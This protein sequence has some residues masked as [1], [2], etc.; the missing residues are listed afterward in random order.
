MKIIAV[1]TCVLILALASCATTQ[2]GGAPGEAGGAAAGSPAAGQAPRQR[3][4]F[5]ARELVYFTAGSP[6]GYAAGALNEYTV[7]EWNSGFTNIVQETRYSASDAALE[8]TEYTYQ[9]NSPAAKIIKVFVPDEK[10]KAQEQVRTQVEYQYDQGRL[11]TETLKNKDGNVVTLYEYVYDGQGNLT[12]RIMKN[13]KGAVMAETVYTWTGGRRVSA[14][15]KNAGGTIISSTQ[16]QYDRQGSLVKEE[17]RNAGGKVTSV[18]TITWQNGLEVKSELTGA[19]NTPQ[20]RETN[21]Y[22][23]GGDLIKKI[24]ENLQGSSAQ[25]IQ[26]EY[27]GR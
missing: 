8:K 2:S 10:G 6:G 19:D 21:E 15:I 14:E 3:N 7:F 1:C 22:N 25:I 27:T 24:I 5:K 17:S 11:R 9:G 4:S 12:S 26:Y 18:L 13:G 16:Y 23:A 20:Q